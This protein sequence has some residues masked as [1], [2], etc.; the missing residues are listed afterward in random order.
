M[1]EQFGGGVTISGGAKKKQVDVA[2]HDM[3]LSLEGAGQKIELDY[4]RVFFQPQ[5]FHD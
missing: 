4:L 3:V 2:H 5:W 1:L